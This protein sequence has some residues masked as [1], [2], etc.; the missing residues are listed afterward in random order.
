MG[1]QLGQPGRVRHVGL[2]ARHVLHLRRIG[3]HQGEV[4]IRQDMPDRF[5]VDPRGLHGD[6]GA[7]ALGQPGGERQQSGGGGREGL[8]LHG[9]F[10]SGREARAGHHAILVHV[11]TGATRVEDFHRFLLRAAGGGHP[12]EEL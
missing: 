2:A 10:A 1:E 4:T 12:S 5:P 7:A 3:Q 11:Q 9:D 6:M 8:H